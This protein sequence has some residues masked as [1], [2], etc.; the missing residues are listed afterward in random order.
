MRRT[1]L[2]VPETCELCGLETQC[3][4]HHV[5]FGT[6]NRRLSDKW[7]MI[8]RLCPSCHSA[9][10][11]NSVIPFGDE[12]FNDMLKK[13]YQEKFQQEHPD[14]CFISIFGRNYK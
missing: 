10:H 6:A 14:E 4:H 8:A 5:F 9:V 13:S 12:T 11:N 2:P 1:P 3:A 7:G